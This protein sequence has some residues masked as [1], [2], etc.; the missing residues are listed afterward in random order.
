MRY[1]ALPARNPQLPSKKKLLLL[2]Y[3]HLFEACSAKGKKIPSLVKVRYLFQPDEL[4]GGVKRA[5]DP[6]RSL[7][8]YSVGSLERS[9]IKPNVPVLYYLHN[10]PKRSFVREEL[11]VVPPNTELPPRSNSETSPNSE[12]INAGMYP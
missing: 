3:Q 5:T 6:T 12:S 9:V 1:Q 8:V 2:S 10:G 4:E 11:L 7:K